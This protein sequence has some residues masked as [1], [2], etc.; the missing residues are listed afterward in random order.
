MIV[1]DSGA[2]QSLKVVART[3]TYHRGQRVRDLKNCLVDIFVPLGAKSTH[4]PELESMKFRNHIF[5]ETT[6]SYAGYC[7]D[8]GPVVMIGRNI[9]C[10]D[11]SH[12]KNHVLYI[13]IG[14]YD[15]LYH[16]QPSLMSFFISWVI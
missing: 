6:F 11:F 9:P 10:D 2:G 7:I 16:V 1:E 5:F 15:R 3:V 14:V 13:I 8:I 12:L 4:V